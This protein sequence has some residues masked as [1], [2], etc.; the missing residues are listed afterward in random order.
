MLQKIEKLENALNKL[1][2]ANSTNFV[3]EDFNILNA[4][5]NSI[6][7]DIN[8]TEFKGET[9]NISQQ[10]IPVIKNLLNKIESIEKKILPKANLL[11]SFSNSNL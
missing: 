10:Y 6:L 1:E 2:E 8:S 7:I 9:V 3:F 4:Q 5:I 11:A